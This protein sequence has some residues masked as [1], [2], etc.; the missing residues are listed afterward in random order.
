M[1][2]EEK[3]EAA[4]AAPESEPKSAQDAQPEETADEQQDRVLMELD[5]E[6]DADDLVDV[7]GPAQLAEELSAG[8]TA[9]DDGPPPKL[10][11][12]QES[13]LA[14][15]KRDG[16][17]V[18]DLEALPEDRLIAIAE[19]RKKMQADVDRMLRDRQQSDATDDETARDSEGT[20]AEPTS[21]QPQ[22]ANLKQRAEE[23]ADYLG[24]DEKGAE[25]LY[26]LQQSAVS[27]QS[28]ESKRLND[29]FVF[30]RNEMLY[31]QLED[32]RRSLESTYPEVADIES[33]EFA[34]VLERMG[35]LNEDSPQR[36]SRKL[37]EDAI[38]LEFKD[39]YRD[40]AAKSK[41]Q[42]RNYRDSGQMTAQSARPDSPEYSSAEE[43]QD[44][45]LRILES[46]DPDKY[47]RARAIGKP[48]L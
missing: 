45:V 36:V 37:M 19:H 20:V 38:L 47:K 27:E 9:S 1:A 10:S 15:L 39:E 25:L 14:V 8:E 24:L 46:N 32:A 2:E 34:R 40:R 17:S 42:I 41:S 6:P 22:S 29:A 12:Q 16:W 33:P 35:T 21:D 13:A 30:V 4:T 28:Q 3:Q 7:G 44:A 18:E 43:R 26:Q 31:M 23:F 5:G 11:E 48:N